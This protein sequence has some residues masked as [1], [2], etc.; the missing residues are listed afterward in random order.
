MSCL[1][2]TDDI[3]VDAMSKKNTDVINVDVMSEKQ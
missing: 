2:N 3:N 1:K